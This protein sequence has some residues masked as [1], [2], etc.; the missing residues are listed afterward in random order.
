MELLGVTGVEGNWLFINANIH[1][2]K[3]QD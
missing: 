1:I 3:L 2:D